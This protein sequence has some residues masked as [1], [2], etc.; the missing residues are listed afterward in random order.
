MKS[1]IILIASGSVGILAGF[2]CAAFLAAMGQ[3]SREEE[4]RIKDLTDPWGV[5]DPHDVFVDNEATKEPDCN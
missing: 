4:A 2:A 3:A 5:G 1:F